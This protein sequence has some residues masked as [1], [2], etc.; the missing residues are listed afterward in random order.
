MPRLLR[1][2]KVQILLAIALLSGLFVASTYYLMLVIDQQRADAMLLRVA[3]RLSYEQQHL[4]MQSMQYQENAPRDYPSYSRDLR[5]YFEDLKRSRVEV[6]RIID[7]LSANRFD[8][9]PETAEMASMCDMPAAA[10]EAAKELADRWQAFSR[11]LDAQIGDDPAAPRLEWAAQTVLAHHAELERLSGELVEIMDRELS[12]RADRARTVNRL[13]FGAAILFALGIGGWFYL[14]V[15]QPMSLALQGFRVVANG[16]FS[17]RVPIAANNEIGWLVAVFNQLADRLDT[18]RLLLTRLEQ[19]GDL[20]S[21]LQTLSDTLPRLMPV[22]WIGVLV[23]GIDG[24]IHLE[25]AYSD[26]E[27][28]PIGQQS[29][30]ADH[31]LL[32]EC[33]KTRQPL[34]IADV[35]QMSGMRETYVFLRRLDELG[36]RDAIF[37]PVGGYS[38][39][40][41]VVVFASRFPNTY[42]TEHLQLLRNL[43]VLVGVSLARTLQLIES[44]RLATIGQFASG[45]VHEVRNPLATIALA[46]EHLTGVEGLPSGSARRVDL[47]TAEVSRLERLLDEIL[48]YAKPIGLQRRPEDVPALLREVVANEPGAG[49]RC[50]LTLEPCPEVLVDRDR[51]RQVMVN[52]LRNALQASPPDGVIRI[53]CTPG[54]RWVEI[55]I[56]NG[57]D[58]VPARE[59]ERLFEPFYT[60]KPQGTGLGLPIVHRLV[61]AHGGS[62]HLASSAET[63]TT[64]TVRLP[65]PA[66]GSQ[67]E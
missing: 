42:T 18:L 34:H 58:P 2:L 60:T 15:L 28:D 27:P 39:R 62:I 25:R 65:I 53:T 56:Q 67:E 11:E 61:S 32:Q 52:L 10:R 43:G 5:F 20:D 12:Q 35:R 9:L 22:D 8:D 26:G 44:Q 36:R 49:N 1:P 7:A 19:G 47:A 13:L 30:D 31:T 3:A 64:A 37:L 45:I 24:R 33:L 57:G 40:E 17:H 48:L 21:T 6:D 41:G 54:G 29:F 14:R 4:T 55:A 51:F 63:G 59:L 23:V 50:V 38:S 16:D 46:L 66:A